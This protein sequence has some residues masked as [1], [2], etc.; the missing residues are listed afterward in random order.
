MSKYCQKCGD[1]KSGSKT[2]YCP[3][4]PDENSS[5]KRLSSLVSEGLSSSN[6]NVSHLA[7]TISIEL[8]KFYPDGASRPDSTWFERK[9]QELKSEMDLDPISHLRLVQDAV[10]DRFLVEVRIFPYNAGPSLAV[11]LKSDVSGELC[12]QIKEFVGSY[13][14]PHFG[15]SVLYTNSWDVIC[16][17]SA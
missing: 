14:P 10:M 9:I 1:Y 15:I 12:S 8:F 11:F 4:V 13:W 6:A 5:W 2:H 16:R 17:N 3:D 7:N